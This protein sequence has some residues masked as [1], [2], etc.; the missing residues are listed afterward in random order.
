MITCDWDVGGFVFVLVR[1]LDIFY[2]LWPIVPH[3]NTAKS[4][5]SVFYFILFYFKKKKKV[6]CSNPSRT[7]TN[8]YFQVAGSIGVYILLL[9]PLIGLGVSCC[10][11]ACVLYS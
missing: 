6:Y 3:Y 10:K 1:F 9:M 7:P 11:F 2:C 4:H 8:L 5:Q